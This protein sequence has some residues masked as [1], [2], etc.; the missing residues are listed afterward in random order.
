MTAGRV[1]NES[2]EIWFTVKEGRGIGH[3]L[4]LTPSPAI[5]QAGEALSSRE[6]PNRQTPNLQVLAAGRLTDVFV[7]V[8]SIHS[9]IDK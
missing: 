3:R 7:A 4:V 6:D 5:S 9:H 1:G 8:T 2:T